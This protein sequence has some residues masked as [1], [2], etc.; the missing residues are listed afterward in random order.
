MY[1][2]ISGLTFALVLFFFKERPPTL[3]SLS[4]MV[5]STDFTKS[6]G[7]MFCDRKFM[8]LA[9]CFGTINGCFNVYGSLMDDILDPY[10][11]T[12]SQVSLMGFLMMFVGIITAVFLGV[13]V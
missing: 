4:S 1:A 2:I 3:P 9:L 5:E 6:I 7:E 10:G 8:T 12:P 13:Y 11:M